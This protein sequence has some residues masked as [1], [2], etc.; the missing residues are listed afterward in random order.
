MQ[1]VHMQ[2]SL[3]SMQPS[4]AVSKVQLLFLTPDYNY[5]RYGKGVT[6]TITVAFLDIHITKW[7]TREI[8]LCGCE[9]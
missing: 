5:W 9:T 7:T 2:F 3:M 6:R 4:S 1:L 8:S